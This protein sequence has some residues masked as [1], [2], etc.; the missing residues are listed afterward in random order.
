M[1]ANNMDE[2]QPLSVGVTSTRGHVKPSLSTN[3]VGDIKTDWQPACLF[4]EA[5]ASL[6]NFQALSHLNSINVVP[7]PPSPDPNAPPKA[8]SSPTPS[9]Q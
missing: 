2:T 4:V 7:F 6:S 8:F 1:A 3:P 9:A 5:G